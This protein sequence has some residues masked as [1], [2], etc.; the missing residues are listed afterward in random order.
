MGTDLCDVCGRLL[1]HQYYV[2]YWG[3]KFCSDHRT[4][5]DTCFSCNR[6]VAPRLTGGGIQYSHQIAICNLCR[7]TEVVDNKKIF[8][9]FR[10]VK[11]QLAL[12]E[13]DLRRIPIYVRLVPINA[14]TL[15]TYSKRWAGLTQKSVFSNNGQIMAQRVD[16]IK[17]LRGLPAEQAL[18]ILAHEAGH[19]WLGLNS[20][21][22]LHPFIEEGL[23]ELIDYLWLLHQNTSEARYR[24]HLKFNNPDPIYG[25]G[26]RTAY[27]AMSSRTL[28]ELLKF[29]KINKQYPQSRSWESR[30]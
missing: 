27:A 15:G 20:F 18:S 6:L 9:L 4:E 22:P 25:E 11:K 30:H 23:C 21:P 24:I 5:Y 16:E 19:A 26:F 28:T 29:V 1:Q 8:D 14:V 3:D 10:Q 13:L 2:N 7:K 17:I 12:L